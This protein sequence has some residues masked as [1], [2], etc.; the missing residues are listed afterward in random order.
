MFISLKNVGR[1]KSADVEIAGITIIAGENNT[2]KSTVGKMLFCIF[3]GF[4]NIE[5]QILL[6]KSLDNMS[7]KLREL[8]IPDSDIFYGIIGRVL[9]NEFDMQINNIYSPEEISK[10]TL[11]I[12]DSEIKMEIQ[13]NN[14]E[15]EIYDYIS[16]KSEIIYIDSPLVI[17]KT[18]NPWRERI[19]D[20]RH[21]L[22]CLLNRDKTVS[23][24][25][26]LVYLK[27]VEK[28]LGLINTACP[29]KMVQKKNED[30]FY[31]EEQ[32]KVILNIETVNMA[33]GLK[34]FAILKTL[35]LDFKILDNAPLIL[36][37]PEI[38]LHPKWQLV[39]AEVI[40]MLQKEFN[41][42]IL[43][44]TH[45]P[46]FLDAIE[47]YSKKHGVSDKCRYYLAEILEDGKSSEI[48]DVTNKLSKVYKK[49]FDPI[50]DLEDEGY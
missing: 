10:I 41:L 4:M 21:L 36:D 11:K 17:D 6:E 5:N 47:V 26:E 13:N 19:P 34:T 39:F 50:Q 40:V 30:F 20:H 7:K 31:R 18:S 37:E 25:E 24:A 9:E 48:S 15:M 45:S 2:G 33:T 35:M 46:Y 43:I 12:K 29:G 14:E 49:L 27:R 28:I 44:N 8:N 23:V 16:L 42:H 1:L 32:K 3:T 38:H 22:R